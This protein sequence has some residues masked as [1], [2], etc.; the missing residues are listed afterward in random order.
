MLGPIRILNFDDSITKQKKLLE[1]FSPVVVDL[2]RYGPTCRLWLNKKTANEIINFL[3]PALRNAIT[4][5]GSSDFHHISCLLIE[6]FTEPI[7]VII[8]DFHPDWDILPPR[9]GCGSWVTNILKSPNIKK[10]IVLGVSSED[11]SSFWIQMGNLSALKGNRVEIF[12]YTHEPTIT[13]L[14]QVPNDNVSIKVAKGL[15]YNKIYWRQMKDINLANLFFEIMGRI[16]TKHVYVSID[17]DCLKS[18]YALTNWEEGY[19]ELKD[20]LNLLKLIKE[21]LKIVGV[22]ITG[23]YS[24]PKMKN[25]IKDIFSRLDHPR[26][27]S[28]KSQAQTIIDSIN[29]QTNIEILELLTS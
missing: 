4:F 20:L 15:F 6:Q 26:N 7:S 29:E 3:Q 22:D 17:K 27:Y 5:L 28:A 8:F 9:L 10:I 2:T 25:R 23:D 24:F 1:R 13:L 12:P 11:I 19:F 14:K 18:S 16:Q 21:N